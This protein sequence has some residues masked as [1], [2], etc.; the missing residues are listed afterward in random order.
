M[1]ETLCSSV[2]TVLPIVVIFPGALYLSRSA[3]APKD[4]L[5][6]NAPAFVEF[7]PVP[8]PPP[9]P[10]PPFSRCGHAS[11]RGGIRVFPFAVHLSLL[12]L[13]LLLAVPSPFGAPPFSPR[14]T[15]IA[16]R[17]KPARSGC[18]LRL[19]LQL[20]LIQ[21]IPR[22]TLL[23]LPSIWNRWNLS[24]PPSPSSRFRLSSTAATRG[25][26]CARESVRESRCVSRRCGETPCA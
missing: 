7:H 12:L 10:S 5:L 22:G 6:C 16:R 26:S 3:R 25:A 17:D 23:L 8:S 2:Y 11:T 15:F 9:S 4:I 24:S 21:R 19:I 14:A 13:P 1:A 20:S 18:R